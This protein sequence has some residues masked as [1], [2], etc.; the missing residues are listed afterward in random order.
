MAQLVEA[1]GRAFF[2]KA[3]GIA[4]VVTAVSGLIIG[5]LGFMRDTRDPRA[6]A[7]Y[8]ETADKVTTLSH[9]VQK[10]AETVK[11]QA[12][13]ISTLQNW[14][15]NRHAGGV[16]VAPL[17]KIMTQQIARPRV[18]VPPKRAPKSWDALTK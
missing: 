4:V 8:E 7:G 11:Q 6:R 1:E 13:E 15:L 10:L 18:T 3:K 16:S 9:D 2:H 17:A 14:V 5:I 12:T